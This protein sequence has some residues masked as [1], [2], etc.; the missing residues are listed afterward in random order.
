MFLYSQQPFGARTDTCKKDFQ[1]T[2][3]SIGT[4]PTF[5]VNFTP[6]EYNLIMSKRLHCGQLLGI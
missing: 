6:L 5:K 3:V 4:N 2:V 1:P